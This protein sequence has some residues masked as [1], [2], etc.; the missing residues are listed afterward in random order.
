MFWK[1]DYQNITLNAIDII[2]AYNEETLSGQRYSSED[3]KKLAS[4]SEKIKRR[5]KGMEK[6]GIDWYDAY[7]LRKE[8]DAMRKIMNR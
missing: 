6:Y 3:I 8:T 1:I 5:I 4:Y 2:K 7:K